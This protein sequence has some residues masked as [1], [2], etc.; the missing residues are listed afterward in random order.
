LVKAFFIGLAIVCLTALVTWGIW[1]YN[2]SENNKDHHCHAQGGEERFYVRG[3]G[4]FCVI[5]VYKE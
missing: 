3:E 5:V 2:V 4:T 1:Y